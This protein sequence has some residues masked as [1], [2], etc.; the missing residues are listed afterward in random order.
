MT[1]ASIEYNLTRIRRGFTL[2][3]MLVVITILVILIALVV[4]SGLLVIGHQNEA[5]TRGI[6]SSL[7]RVMVE[8]QAELKTDAYPPFVTASYEKVPGRKIVIGG[9]DNLVELYL[10]REQVR[11]PDT[12]VFL[13][14]AQGIGQ[15]NSIISSIGARF[16]VTTELMDGD[17][18]DSTNEMDTTPSILDAWSDAEGWIATSRTGDAEDAWPLLHSSAHL[19]FYV[20]P[21]NRLAQDL[22]GRCVNGRPYFFSAGA[23]GLYGTTSQLTGDGTDNQSEMGVNSDGVDLTFS[24]MAVEALE[25]NIYSYEVAPAL[26]NPQFNGAYR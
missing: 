7:D 5:T 20:H 1:K 3:E 23:D 9:A 26:D 22:Y 21:A 19:I 25:D 11:H 13:R 8:Y 15:V 24:E 16:T 14:Q 12:S 2:V 6:L 4:A 18:D 17:A 10:N